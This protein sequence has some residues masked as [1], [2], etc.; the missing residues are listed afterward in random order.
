MAKLDKSVHLKLFGPP[1]KNNSKRRKQTDPD[2]RTTKKVSDM[3]SQILEAFVS[4]KK[5]HMNMQYNFFVSYQAFKR[6]HSN[7]ETKQIWCF[8]LINMRRY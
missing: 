2:L 4:K 1:L 5:F 7:S 8:I 6:G 3:R